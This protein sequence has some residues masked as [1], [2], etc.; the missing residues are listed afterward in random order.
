MN[1]KFN[2][3]EIRKIREGLFSVIAESNGRVLA[4]RVYTFPR[5]FGR[6]NPYCNTANMPTTAVKEIG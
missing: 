5:E 4:S 3:V 2:V 1:D 6:L